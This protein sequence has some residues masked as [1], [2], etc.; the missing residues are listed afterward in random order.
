MLFFLL[1]Q[2][3]LPH[4]DDACC[5]WLTAQLCY[6][7]SILNWSHELPTSCVLKIMKDWRGSKGILTLIRNVLGEKHTSSLA[8]WPLAFCGRD[9]MCE[10]CK[11]RR[12]IAERAQRRRPPGTWSEYW[13]SRA[14]GKPH[15]TFRDVLFSLSLDSWTAKLFVDQ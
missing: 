11:H 8:G 1:T 12:L 15:Y 9:C 14:L 6:C 4:S 13:G 10:K 3:M 5:I 2:R 7:D